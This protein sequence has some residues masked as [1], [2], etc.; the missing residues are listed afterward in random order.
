MAETIETIIAFDYGSKKIGVAVGQTLS[1]TA[2][3]LTIVGQ[4]QNKIQWP[5][6]EKIIAEWRPSRLVLG[7]PAT[8][9]GQT[10]DIHAAIERFKRDLER[11]FSLPVELCDERLSSFEAAEQE[12]QSRHELDAIAAQIIL[13]TWLNARRSQ[14]N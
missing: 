2:E 14:E 10:T 3:P 12:Q 5:A 6:I 4:K 1:N 8:D 13:Q 9:D 11:R 7:F